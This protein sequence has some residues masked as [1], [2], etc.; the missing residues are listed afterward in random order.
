MLL[1]VGSFVWHIADIN[2]VDYAS[3]MRQIF[4]VCLPIIHDVRF[5]RHVMAKLALLLH[6]VPGNDCTAYADQALEREM[7]LER[8]QHDDY[9]DCTSRKQIIHLALDHQDKQVL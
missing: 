9:I 3:F 1:S 5:G 4:Q 7:H 8:V 2:N 6:H